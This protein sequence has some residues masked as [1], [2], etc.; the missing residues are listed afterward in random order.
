MAWMNTQIIGETADKA[1]L[2]VNR[3]QYDDV[4]GTSWDLIPEELAGGF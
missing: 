4:V 1:S 3:G 2:I